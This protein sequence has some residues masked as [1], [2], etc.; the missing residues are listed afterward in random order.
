MLPLEGRNLDSI[1]EV[2]LAMAMDEIGRLSVVVYDM[3]EDSFKVG[4]WQK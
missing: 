2:M 3:E 1:V 4:R